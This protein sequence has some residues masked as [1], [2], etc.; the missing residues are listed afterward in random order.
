[1]F[2]E[3]LASAAYIVRLLFTSNQ[4]MAHIFWSDP[5][6]KGTYKSTFTSARTPGATGIMDPYK[7]GAYYRA[8]TG[9]L[10][11]TASTWR[12]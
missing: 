9:T 5:A 10:S 12:P 6:R 8:V 3:T 11:M 7:P 4:T 2:A 1:M